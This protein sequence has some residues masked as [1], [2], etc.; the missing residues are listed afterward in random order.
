MQLLNRPCAPDGRAV[1]VAAD[2]D[3]ALNSYSKASWERSL[4][5]RTLAGVSS[6]LESHQPC[7]SSG[8]HTRVHSLHSLEPRCERSDVGEAIACTSGSRTLTKQPALSS[9]TT[10]KL[11]FLVVMHT[12]HVF[13]LSVLN[14]FR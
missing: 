10:R 14:G 8:V 13:G 12:M 4:L 11:H 2:A 9:A 3:N 5:S 6:A 1:R 7:S